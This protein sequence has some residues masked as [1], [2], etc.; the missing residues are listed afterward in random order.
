MLV[1]EA[2]AAPFRNNLMVD[3]SV[4][5]NTDAIREAYGELPN[6]GALQAARASE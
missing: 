6:R 2:C 4:D 5:I 3:R 1:D